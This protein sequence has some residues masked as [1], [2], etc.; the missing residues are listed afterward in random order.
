MFSYQSTEIKSFSKNGSKRVTRRNNVVVKGTKGTKTVSIMEN[1]K[2]VHKKT[3]PLTK[4][5]IEC[6]GRREFVPGLF[7]DC[8]MMRKK[9]RKTRRLRK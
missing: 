6:I 9:G 8:M 4:Q 7:K 5:E 3:I 1:G 2:K